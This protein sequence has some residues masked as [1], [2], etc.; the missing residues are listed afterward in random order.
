[1]WVLGFDSSI[2]LTQVTDPVSSSSSVNWAESP[3]PARLT[4]L[5]EA[6]MS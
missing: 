4:E 3:Y 6:Q 5:C 1:M 2:H